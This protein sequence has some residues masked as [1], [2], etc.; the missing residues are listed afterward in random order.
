MTARRLSQYRVTLC[1]FV[2]LS[3]ALV[4]V[5]VPTIVGLASVS[6]T[7]VRANLGALLAAVGI[8]MAWWTGLVAVWTA[9]QR[10]HER[11]RTE[12]RVRPVRVA[13]AE[14]VRLPVPKHVPLQ[15]VRVA[16]AER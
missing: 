15:R 1:A 11:P 14:S 6:S 2:A 12:S 3:V 16:V 8:M 10:L 9:E 7:G 4:T 5:A 13:S